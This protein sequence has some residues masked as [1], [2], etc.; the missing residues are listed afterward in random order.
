MSET[1]TQHLAL[2]QLFAVSE[3]TTISG[4]DVWSA[5]ATTAAHILRIRN[6]LIVADTVLFGGRC[7]PARRAEMDVA[8]V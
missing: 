7:S 5:D 4:R 6:G 1:I 3:A 2:D 8:N